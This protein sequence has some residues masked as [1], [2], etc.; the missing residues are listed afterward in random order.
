MENAA[1]RADE[2][3][4]KA[5]K[6]LQGWSLF[7]KK[8]DEV[9]EL[10]Q[11]AANQYKLAK[12]WNDAAEAYKQLADVCLKMDSK[13]EAATAYVE[14]AKVCAKVN[15]PVA[16]FMLQQAVSLYTEMGRLNMAARQLKELAEVNE[17]QGAREEALV[18]YTQAA[19]LFATESATSEAN[20]CR[21]KV[22][23]FSADLEQYPRAVEIY[24]DVART[25]VENN[26]L[27]Y[28]AKGYLLQAG[29]CVLCYGSD[30]Q[31]RSKVEAYRDIDLNFA[32]SRECNLLEALA[33]ALDKCDEKGFATSVAEYDAM[34]RLDN[35]K[36]N[37]LLKVKRRI[38]ARITGAEADA[39]EDEDVL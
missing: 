20:K 5:Q 31:I 19:D 37:M 11:Q 33:D 8:Y 25:C 28:S 22:A 24:E 17:K 1:S 21:L 29:F 18:F 3:M 9:A 39:D 12:A 16:T 13:H 7:G 15:A 38:N 32:G 6:K 14:G 30:D 36:T 23:E 35:W 34:T 4:A 10:F 26:L 2:C 27:K